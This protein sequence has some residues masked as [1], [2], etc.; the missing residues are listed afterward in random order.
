MYDDV[1]STHN[2]NERTRMS[3][4][5]MS[6][7]FGCFTRCGSAVVWLSASSP[8]ECTVRTLWVIGLRAKVGAVAGLELKLGENEAAKTQQK[9]ID[10]SPGGFFSSF[11][12][13]RSS[14]ALLQPQFI[15]DNDDGRG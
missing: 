6:G 9:K 11:A 12:Q 4:M 3:C 8:I 1:K 13:L 5:M 15:Y 2:Y 14:P 7:W 10:N